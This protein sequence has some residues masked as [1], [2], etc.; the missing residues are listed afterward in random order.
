M[1]TVNIEQVRNSMT[2]ERC[3]RMLLL[4]RAHIERKEINETAVKV[5]DQ[6]KSKSSVEVRKL[7]RERG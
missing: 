5:C 1:R 4:T 6:C 7:E 2:F 3:P